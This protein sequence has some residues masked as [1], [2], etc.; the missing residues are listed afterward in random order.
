MGL[1]T[2]TGILFCLVSVLFLMPAM[3]GWSEAHHSKR[4]SEPR[5]HIFA[6]G[7]EQLSASR[8]ASR[9][10]RSPSR[11]AHHRRRWRGAA[12]PVR[13][14]R[15]GAP[16]ARQPRHPGAEE[17]NTHFGSGFESMSLVLKATTLPEVLA[18]ADKAAR[19]T[20]ASSPTAGSEASTQ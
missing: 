11:R 2:G 4:E 13:R 9:A 3:L 19:R 20:E 12:A 18:L 1:L 6:F 5:L 14:Q 16:A 15:R 8:C 7:I 10:R 17:I